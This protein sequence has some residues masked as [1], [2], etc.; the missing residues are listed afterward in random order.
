M[1]IR[2]RVRTILASMPMMISDKAVEIRKRLEIMV[3]MRASPNTRAICA[4]M[5]VI[6]AVFL[7]Q[8]LVI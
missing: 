5:L 7:S 4:Q 3:A 8:A 6:F 1:C 2:D